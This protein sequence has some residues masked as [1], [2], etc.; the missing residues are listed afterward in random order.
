[1]IDAT[2]AQRK[3]PIYEHADDFKKY[4]QN[5][6]RRRIHVS[7]RIMQIEKIIAERN[8]KFS[9]EITTKPLLSKRLGDLDCGQCLRGTIQSQSLRSQ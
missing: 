3:R 9:G 6:G 1:M 7:V 5:K 8:W 2:D 4:L